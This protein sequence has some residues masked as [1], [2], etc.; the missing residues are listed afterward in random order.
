MESP[1]WKMKLNERKYLLNK[2]KNK[3][4]KTFI[5]GANFGP[6]KND[7]F[8]ERYK[9]IFIE[10]D[11]ICFRDNYSYNLFKKFKNVRL[12]PDVVFNLKI[13]KSIP[14][15]KTV[16]FS[17]I[18]LSKREELKEYSIK[19]NK[20]MVELVEHC[21]NEGYSIKLFSFCENEGDLSIANYIKKSVGDKIKD[22]I[23]IINYQGNIEEFLA[24]F[25]SCELIIGTRFHSII[26]ALLFNQGLFPIIY[27]E[28]TLNV[29]RD[30]NMTK[31]F[32]KVK[33][34]DSL[35]VKSILNKAINNRLEKKS[36][37]TESKKQF[38][39]L[40]LFLSS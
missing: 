23:K 38:Q 3:K 2:F 8:A 4:K 22:N 33:D 30:L 34:L 15:E 37:L 1:A 24:E 6:Y 35:E 28:K 5:I 10:Y 12:A 18:D 32:C 17:F 7:F 40:D 14:K 27:S 26:L 19:S 25:H 20:K 21:S 11:D 9:E 31:N 36:V 13:N 16:G 39:E 29:L